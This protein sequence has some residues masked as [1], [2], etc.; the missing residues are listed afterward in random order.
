MHNAFVSVI[1]GNIGVSKSCGERLPGLGQSIQVSCTE[2]GKMIVS[3]FNWDT[4]NSEGCSSPC[5]LWGEVPVDSPHNDCCPWLACSCHTWRPRGWCFL[6]WVDGKFIQHSFPLCTLNFCCGRP[7]VPIVED[8]PFSIH[9]WTAWVP[10]NATNKSP[11]HKVFLLR[12]NLQPSPIDL[13]VCGQWWTRVWGTSQII[14]SM[15]NCHQMLNIH[16]WGRKYGPSFKAGW[17]GFS[18]IPACFTTTLL[19]SLHCLWIAW[20][21]IVNCHQIFSQLHCQG[22]K[23]SLMP[24]EVLLGSLGDE[25]N[26]AEQPLVCGICGFWHLSNLLCHWGNN[27]TLR[28]PLA[29]SWW[30]HSVHEV[31][32]WLDCTEIKF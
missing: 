7:S 14:C 25:G 28:T 18:T 11:C 2:V 13:G 4:E 20:L 12:V 16:R 8:L 9:T 15:A 24:S 27:W 10:H 30:T 21:H 29:M 5:S 31:T 3:Q 26:L 6:C 22:T 17:M 19:L 23:P 1:T 32:R